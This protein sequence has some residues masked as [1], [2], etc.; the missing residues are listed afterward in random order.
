[1]ILRAQD[2]I[3]GDPLRVI[4]NKVQKQYDSSGFM[5]STRNGPTFFVFRVVL[6]QRRTKMHRA[7]RLVPR[8]ASRSAGLTPANTAAHGWNLSLYYVMNWVMRISH[9]AASPPE[10][11]QAARAIPSTSSSLDM[12]G[13]EG[14][15]ALDEIMSLRRMVSAEKAAAAKAAVDMAAKVKLAEPVKEKDVDVTMNHKN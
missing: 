14:G 2:P 8:S 15:A 4:F 11:V 1:M 13:M 5:L 9:D 10:V 12:S 7:R 3:D 6:R